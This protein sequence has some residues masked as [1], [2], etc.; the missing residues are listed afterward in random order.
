[1]INLFIISIIVQAIFFI[2]AYSFATDKFTDLSY[3]LTFI[4]LTYFLYSLGDQ[5]FEKLLLLLMI[6]IWG[7]R[8]GAY[9]VGRIFKTGRDKRFDGMRENIIHFLRF[10]LFQGLTVPVILLPTAFFMKANTNFSPILVLGFVVWLMGIII[11]GVSDSQKYNFINNPKNHGKWVNIG[12]W[13]Y[14][15]HPN[16]LGEILCWLG[17]YVYVFS[18]LDLIGRIVGLLSPLLITTLLTFI[19]G[20]PILEKKADKKWGKIKEYILYKKRTPILLPHIK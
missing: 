8:L 5:S 7:L 10:W 13:K 11:E 12:L 3:S 9:L 18:S 17:I 4:I 15:R 2:P 19:T 16:Y 14:S 6:S 1:V 20:I